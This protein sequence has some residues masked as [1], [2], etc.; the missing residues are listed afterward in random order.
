MAFTNGNELMND[1]TAVGFSVTS[2]SRLVVLR[3]PRRADGRRPSSRQLS[4]PSDGGDAP[5]R[6]QSRASTR[7]KKTA[8]RFFARSLEI[9]SVR[10]AV[11]DRSCSRTESRWLSG[12][13]GS[14]GQ[15]SSIRKEKG[16]NRQSARMQAGGVVEGRSAVR[17]F[18]VS[19][20][21]GAR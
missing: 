4:D 13:R 2:G 21:L 9:S 14:S 20:G 12:C 18:P 16:G 8:G 10:A 3:G 1:R 5:S 17:A 11:G 6:H 7:T 15:S 19:Q